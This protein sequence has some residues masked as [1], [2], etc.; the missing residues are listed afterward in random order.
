MV[1]KWEMEEAIQCFKVIESSLRCI[2][3]GEFHMYRALSTQ[4]RILLCDSPKPLL[5]RL[6]RNLELQRLADV[7]S[8]KPG[9][10]PENLAHLNSIMVS[11]ESPVSISCMPFEATIYFNG[12]EDCH[13]IPASSGEMIDLEKW[14]DQVITVF[15]Q[16]LTIRQLIR[17]VADRGGG[18]HVH[19]SKDALLSGLANIQ[20]PTKLNQPALVIVA[21]SKFMQQIGLSVEQLYERHGLKGS[22]PLENFDKQHKSVIASA[23]VPAECFMHPKQCFNLLSLNAS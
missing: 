17:T 23:R 10:F 16:P 9:C 6:F 21:I 7:D 12:V 18:A 13:P 1:E 11:G 3:A 19:K 4:L 5:V 2:Y 20:T 8:Y 15:P 14:V 22:L